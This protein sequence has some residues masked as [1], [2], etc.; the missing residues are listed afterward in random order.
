MRWNLRMVAAQRG[1]WKASDLRR[2][3]AEAGLELSAG[4]MSHLWSQTPISIRLDDLD[5]ICS[6]LE[7]DPADLLIP[8]AQVAEP[9]GP[10]VDAASDAPTVRPRRGNR[11]RSV[12]PV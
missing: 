10:A 12:P 4:K 5:V 6:V 8:E 9:A 7:C 11:G 2:A 3:L 1:V